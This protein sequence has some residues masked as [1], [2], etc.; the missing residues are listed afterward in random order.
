MDSVC[1]SN[2]T[3]VNKYFSKRTIQEIIASES[4][5]E[6]V[7]SELYK[8]LGRYYRNEYYYKNTLFNKLVVGKY[9]LNT[10]YAMSEVSISKSRADFL[11]VNNKKA[12]I[13]EIKTELDSLD[14]L[15][16]Q[17][18]DYYKVCSIV[19]ILVSEDKYYPAYRLL[20][21]HKVGICVLTKRNSISVRKLPVQDFSKLKHEQLFKLLRKKEYESLV[22]KEFGVDKKIKDVQKFKAYLKKF[23]TLD[24]KYAQKMVF[25]HLNRRKNASS[26]EYIKKV[27]FELRW[28]V[29][30]SSLNNEKYERFLKNIDG[31]D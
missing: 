11:V 2:N 1:H 19:Y 20:K 31:G 9:S 10:T 4:N 3:L 25:V 23:K 17:I 6:N 7:W 8:Y 18:E 24:I 22:E 16:Y 21:D 13:F 15:I 30:Q 27:P 29:Y 5:V 26:A 28:L 12:F 14:K